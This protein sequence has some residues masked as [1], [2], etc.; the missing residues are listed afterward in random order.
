[1]IR[2]QKALELVVR[3][4]VIEIERA[5]KNIGKT[6]VFSNSVVEITCL[7]A[8]KTWILYWC[9]RGC[10]KRGERGVRVHN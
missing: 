1:M 10:P 2:L 9:F 3:L 8:W 4:V 6:T 5:Y 7:P